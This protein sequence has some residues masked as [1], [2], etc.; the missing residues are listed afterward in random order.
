M[1]NPYFQIKYESYK[2]GCSIAM[3]YFLPVHVNRNWL[4]FKFKLLIKIN[5]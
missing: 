2:L 5:S 1:E 3:Y 4:N